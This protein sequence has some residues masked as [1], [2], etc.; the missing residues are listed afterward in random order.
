VLDKWYF[1]PYALI[2]AFLCVGPLA[3][4]LVWFSPRLSRKNKTIISIITLVLSYLLGI[5]FVNSLKSIHEYYKLMF[6]EF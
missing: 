1:K 2:I 6:Q 3:L 4:P 5:L